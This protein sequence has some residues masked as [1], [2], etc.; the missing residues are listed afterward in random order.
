M[1]VVLIV[2]IG[3]VLAAY[4][5]PP[6]LEA[7]A[8]NCAALD[9]RVRRLFDFEIARLRGLNGASSPATAPGARPPVPGGGVIS[10]L[11]RA[12]LPFLPPEAACAAAYWTSVFQPDLRR[13]APT[14]FPPAG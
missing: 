1:R 9:A 11:V 14:L 8:D 7:T 5:M 3:L 13:Y 2:L 6:R 4:V 12:N 10:N